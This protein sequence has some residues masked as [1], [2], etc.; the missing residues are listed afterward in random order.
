LRNIDARKQETKETGARRQENRSVGPSGG[1]L[2]L[3]ILP[4]EWE[5]IGRD[6]QSPHLPLNLP[7]R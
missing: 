4:C 2:P 7:R 3:F 6:T 5:P 1:F